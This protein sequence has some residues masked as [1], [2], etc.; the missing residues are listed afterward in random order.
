MQNQ[1]MATMAGM[2]ANAG[3]VDGGTPMM[4]N[5]QRPNP[6]GNQPRDDPR[7]NLNTYIYDYFMR[8][9]NFDQ[10]RAMLT[11]DLKMNILPQTKSSPSGRKMNGVDPSDDPADLPQPKLPEGQSADNS[12]LFDW[13]C[14]FWD[15]YRAARD[16]NGIKGPSHQYY[17]HTRNMGAMQNVQRTERMAMAGAGMNG[18]AIN[19]AGLNPQQYQNMMRA[20]AMQNG[21][22]NDLKRAAMNN[23][24]PSN[25]N[26][27]ANMNAQMKNQMLSAAQM[28]RDGSGMDMNGQ[29]PQSPGSSENAPSPNKRPRVEGN[30]FNGQPMGAR[31]QGMPQQ[32]MGAT[33]AAQAN[34]MLLA[35]GMNSGQF[36]EFAQQAPNVQPKSLEVYAQSLAHQQ[37]IALNNHALAQGLNSGIQGSPMT[38]PG[39]DGQDAIFSGNVPRPGGMP[40]GPGAPGQPQGNHALQDYQMQLMLLEQQNKKRLLMAR[41]EQDN[42]SG[43]QHGQP[44]VG[45]PGFPPSMSPQGSRAGPSPNPNDQMKRGTPKLPGSPMPDPSMQQNR[46]S[47]APNMDFQQ[48]PP[49]FPPQFY[50][51][52][53]QQN[54]MMRPPSSHPGGNMNGQQLT[55]QQMEVMRA[56]QNGAMQ[57]GAWRG[58]PQGMMPQQGQQMG[59]MGNPQQ[60]NP[61]PPPPAPP[62]GEQPRAQEPSPSQP[63]AP[64]TPN[65][66]N[67]ANP[68]KKATNDKK[69]PAKSKAAGTGATPA[70][71]G[72]EPPPTPTTPM[73]AK[74]FTGQNGQQPPQPQTQPPA[75]AP[76]PQQQPMQ[77]NGDPTPFGALPGDEPDLG[78]TFGFDGTDAL[79]NFDFDSFLHVGDDSGAFGSLG[80]DF[81]FGDGVEAGGEL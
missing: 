12:F 40:A 71:S 57:N 65:Q 41:Q 17:Q 44:P 70:A 66:T 64:P 2:N 3:P 35:G 30:N 1:Q 79:E 56:Q 53:L 23:R 22:P 4:S 8:N 19:G 54:P 46:N 81:G 73:N 76:A 68:K 6:N 9:K 20:G 28:Q 37:R 14:Q 16:K 74:S 24:N 42:M 43:P 29:R 75:A 39:L 67:K 55:Q 48:M 15:I 32:P 21:V 50:N 38:Q 27:M 63:A 45:A 25:P 51:P 18:G 13:W 62:A 77:T 59:P 31:S 36:G 78:L 49:G 72:E 58:P 10:A 26:Q 34:P 5:M 61:M 69:K 7:I 33:T 52:Q 80:G 47:P 11:G 60:R